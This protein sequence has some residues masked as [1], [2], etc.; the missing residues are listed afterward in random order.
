[1][2]PLLA[3]GNLRVM[4]VNTRVSRNTKAMVEAVRVRA[5]ALP[6]VCAQSQS[7]RCSCCFCCNKKAL[8]EGG[9]QHNASQPCQSVLNVVS[10]GDSCFTPSNLEH[11]SIPQK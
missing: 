7:F 5:L 10:V 4:L 8:V 3:P 11:F 9:E 6:K 2:T 1:M